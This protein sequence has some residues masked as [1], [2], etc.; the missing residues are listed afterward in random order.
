MGDMQAKLGKTLLKSMVDLR[1]EKGNISLQDVGEIFMEMASSLSPDTSNVD[2]FVHEEIERLAK[3]IID[4]KKEIF[5]MQTNDKSE[6]VIMDAS[7]HLDEVIKHTEEA[8][9][10]IMD[11]CDKVQAGAT[12]IGGDKEAAIMEATN[13]IFDACTFQDIT[14]Q[15]IRKVIKLL[16]NIEER[17]NKLNDMMGDSP[18]FAEA[19]ANK[20]FSKAA[21]PANDKDLLNGPQLKGQGTNQSDIDALF[22]SLGGN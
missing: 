2:K 4:T 11:A 5:A 10:T 6:D 15:R 20:D 7:A 19:E 13:A 14:G 9:N 8:T 1:Q 22:A 17:I 16:E 21:V 12:G 18:I 3:Y